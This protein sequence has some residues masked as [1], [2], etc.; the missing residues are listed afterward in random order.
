MC[1]M[2]LLINGEIWENQMM[3]KG[4]LNGVQIEFMQN[5][6]LEWNEA[7]WCLKFVIKVENYDM[8]IK[9]S[10]WFISIT[11]LYSNS[12]VYLFYF[13]LSFSLLF[14]NKNCKQMEHLFFNKKWT[15]KRKNIEFEKEVF[16]TFKNILSKI[17]NLFDGVSK[18][19]FLW[20]SFFYS[21]NKL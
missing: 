16:R 7:K 10:N 13:L 5:I 11:I 6:H 8:L 2:N 12:I 4:V 1:K 20:Y 3:E 14:F 19:S 21:F 15:K 9:I 17:S 18:Y